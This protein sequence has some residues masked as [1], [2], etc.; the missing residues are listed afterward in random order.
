MKGNLGFW[1][2]KAVVMGYLLDEYPGAGVAY[3][4]ARKL[5]NGYSG[6]AIRVQ[7]QNDSSEQDIGFDGSGNLDESA[8]TSFVGANDA[9]VVTIYDQSGNGA[10]LTASGYFEIV[11]A[12]VIH[13]ENGRVKVLP[14]PL[15]GTFEG[16]TA[17]SN[18]LGSS[19]QYI[20]AKG[21]L[22]GFVFIPYYSFAGSN[23]LLVSDLNYYA[24]GDPGNYYL[25]T[26]F[27]SP[28]VYGDN[29]PSSGSSIIIEGVFAS[30]SSIKIYINGTDDSDMVENGA[31]TA[32]GT[33]QM[34]V[35]YYDDSDFQ[36]LI[37]W[38][39]DQS[40]NRANIYTNLNSYYS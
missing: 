23:M 20:I 4:V 35:C 34:N 7:R 25:E 1:H 9:I 18:I 33:E 26:N 17:A 2:Y 31:K 21:I 28:F 29:L 39:S 3:S 16:T 13:K 22:G 38:P 27:F 40:A 32:S 36:E 19:Q 14:T 12:G 11:S 24:I 15:T 10:D 8:L 5:R 37:I 6:F 30:S